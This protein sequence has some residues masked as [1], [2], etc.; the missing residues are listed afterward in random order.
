MGLASKAKCGGWNAPIVVA[1]SQY[2]AP[3][4]SATPRTRL[5]CVRVLS[6]LIDR[7]LLRGVATVPAMYTKL[8]PP[9]FNALLRRRP[10]VVCIPTTSGTGSEVTPFAV[11][12]DDQGRKVRV[13]TWARLRN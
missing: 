10:Q 13:G 6:R 8:T 2:G 3:R 11:I 1:R 7:L 5:G 4:V 9:P 12:T